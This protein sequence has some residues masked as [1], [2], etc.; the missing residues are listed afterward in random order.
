MSACAARGSGLV[1]TA[2]VSGV[3]LDRSSAPRRVANRTDAERVAVIVKLRTVADD[4]GRDRRDAGDAAL[5]RLGD[6]DPD[7]DG[8]AR[9]ARTRAAVRYERSRPGELV[10]IDVKKLGRIV[11]GAGWR[12]RGG[13]QHYTPRRTDTAGVPR[14]TAGWEYV[15]VAVDDYSRLAYAEVLPDEKAKT[16]AAFLRRARRLLPPLR[17]P[18]RGVITDNGA[19]YISL[20]A[21]TRLPPA[22]DPPPAHP[23]LP[24]T[25]K[26]ESRA[27]HP[28]HAHRLGLRRHLRLK[29]RTHRRP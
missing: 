4:G 3:L 6:P 8:Q 12:V 24:P 11:G 26:R 1:A 21:R 18:G 13:H 2:A 27:L 23:P 17:H 16:A 5:D 29:P 28:H 7:R 25:D 22:Q 14:G 15:H 20:S 9:P 19:S 10:H